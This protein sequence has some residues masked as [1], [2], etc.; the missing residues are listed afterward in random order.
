MKSR[1]ISRKALSPVI[2]ALILIVVTVI[3]SILV[4]MWMGALTFTFMRVN[5][6]LELQAAPPGYPEIGGYWSLLVYKI[7]FS[8]GRPVYEYAENATVVVDVLTKTNTAETYL[9]LTDDNGR[10]SFQYFEKYSE[11]CF[12]SF[13]EGYEASNRIVLNQRY[14]HGD[15]LTWLSSFSFTSL[16]LALGGGSY[17]GGK[18]KSLFGRILYWT[19]LFILSISSFILVSTIYSFLFESTLWGFSS[20]IIAPVITFENLKYLAFFTVLLYIFATFLLYLDRTKKNENRKPAKGHKR[21][22]ARKK[23]SAKAKNL[24][25]NCSYKGG[26]LGHFRHLRSTISRKKA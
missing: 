14:V 18:R 9:L 21:K 8:E 26:I 16:A 2:A 13:L 10:A 15:T 6:Y 17:L 5:P 20:E 22:P 3:V 19:L 1:L 7:N 25:G 24:K 11:V 4:V 23:A 12:Q